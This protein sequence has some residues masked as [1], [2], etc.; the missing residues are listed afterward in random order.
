MSIGKGCFVSI[1]FLVCY[2]GNGKNEQAIDVNFLI[3]GVYILQVQEL[4][5][6]FKVAF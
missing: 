6:S 1:C 2:C 4:N 3:S 5:S